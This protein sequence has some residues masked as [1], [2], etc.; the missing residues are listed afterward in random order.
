MVTYCYAE[1][2][3]KCFMLVLLLE[4]ICA[5]QRRCSHECAAIYLDLSCNVTRLQAARITKAAGVCEGAN[6]RRG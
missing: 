3:F 4:V 1:H 5:Q 6:D 2:L